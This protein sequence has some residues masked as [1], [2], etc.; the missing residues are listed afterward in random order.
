[1]DRPPINKSGFRAARTKRKLKL[2]EY[3]ELYGWPL[4]TV[5]NACDRGWPI[6]DPPELLKKVMA[7]K[8]KKAP[9]QKLLNIVNGQPGVPTVDRGQRGNAQNAPASKQ[10]P[11]P[12][13]R[14]PSAVGELLFSG[15]AA[16]LKRLEDETAASYAK[17]VAEQQ[18]GEKMALQKIYLANV[19][20][21]RQLAK[22]A[23]KADAGA[24]KVLPISDVDSAWSRS[25]KEFRSA[26]ESM[27]RRV[28]TQPL[29]K[30]LDPVDVEQLVNKEV[31][32][33][34]AHLETGSWLRSTEE[35]AS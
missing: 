20:A 29:F 26:L 4:Q 3:M 13:P 6:D 14:D 11:P 16:E 28:A 9:I 34:L 27:P 17:Y 8:G 15:L 12:P 2:R 5:R 32:E 31:S 19:N 10:P 23:P 30:K 33:I 7:S 18:P 1:M 22:D 21:L 35:P 25:L 24:K